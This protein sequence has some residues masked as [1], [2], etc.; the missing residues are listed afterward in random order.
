LVAT[1]IHHRVTPAPQKSS[2][3]AGLHLQILTLESQ[4]PQIS[5]SIDALNS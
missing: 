5:K 3:L 4:N 2:S 1:A